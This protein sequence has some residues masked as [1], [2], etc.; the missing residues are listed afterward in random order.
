LGECLVRAAEDAEDRGV[1]YLAES[2]SLSKAKV[3][4]HSWFAR[5]YDRA[6]AARLEEAGIPWSFAIALMGVVDA[7]RRSSL[8]ARATKGKWT[9]AR[10]RLEL[11]SSQPPRG[12]GGRQRQP[13][14]TQGAA[15]DFI[16]LESATREWGELYAAWGTEEQ[17]QQAIAELRRL[18]GD[19]ETQLDWTRRLSELVEALREL[20]RWA[21]TLAD[22]LAG[23]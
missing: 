22:E 2:L 14:Q 18:T 5:N 17:R 13:R 6:E 23:R 19:G 20:S 12:S 9:L 7:R 16:R 10:L 21:G 1:A 8:L 3:Y 11:R 4:Q 15:V